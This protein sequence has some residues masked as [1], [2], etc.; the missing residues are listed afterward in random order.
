MDE[1][2]LAGLYIT[3]DLGVARWLCSRSYVMY[4]GSVVESGVTG[5]I[6]DTPSHDYTRRLVA[7]IPRLSDHVPP[8]EQ[9]PGQPRVQVEKL[10]KRFREKLAV[11]AVTFD[12]LPGE[13]F[14]IVGESGS[15]KST[16]ANMICGLLEPTEGEMRVNL[17]GSDGAGSSARTADRNKLQMV[18]QDPASALNPRQTI[19][20]ILELPLKLRGIASEARQIRIRD[21]LDKVALPEDVLRRYPRSLS[22]GQK[23]RV[24]IARALAMEPDILVLDEPT[25]ALD[26]SVQ[27]R[28]LDLLKSLRET[29]KLTYILITH[30]LGVV[31]AMADRV[32]V[33]YH[34][35]LV[36]LGKADD[37]LS[38]PSSDYTR[39]LLA[40]VPTLEGN[41]PVIER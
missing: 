27:A 11:N 36:E 13:T 19:G 28:I 3:H 16:L 26:V 8:R 1:H 25:S 32:A 6:L 35:D 10:T 12:V 2:A 9:M 39:T 31:R 5:Q 34:G 4:R 15:G 29:E 37:I 17:D 24:C 40:A 22:G 14:A 41:M 23:Q 21:L 30:D 20:Q 33:L 7:A 38:A 18:W